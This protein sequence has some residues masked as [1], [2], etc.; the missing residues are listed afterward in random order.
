VVEPAGAKAREAF[1]L[2]RISPEGAEV[3]VAPKVIVQWAADSPSPDLQKQIQD[4]LTAAG[5]AATL[6]DLLRNAE[7]AAAV[8]PKWEAVPWIQA[9]TKVKEGSLTRN[10]K[11]LIVEVL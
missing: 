11:E 4:Q 9:V 6:A 5:S 3:W 2:E 7:K 1:F 8:I 10:G